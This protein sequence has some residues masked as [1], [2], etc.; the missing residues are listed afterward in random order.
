MALSGDAEGTVP[1]FIAVGDSDGY[2]TTTASSITTG[3]NIR[4][5]KTAP[6]ITVNGANPDTVFLNSQSYTDP[7]ASATDSYDGAVSVNTSGSVNTNVVGSYTLTYSAS[8]AAGNAASSTRTVNVVASQGG[9]GIVGSDFSA[10]PAPV[11]LA[12]NGGAPALTDTGGSS[13]SIA[14]IATS[15]AAS[16]T[17]ASLT[18]QLQ[19]LYQKIKAM[20]AATTSSAT[21]SRDLQYGD[22]GADVL[23][24]QQFLNTNGYVVATSGPGSPGEETGYFGSATRKSLIAFQKALGIMPTA[25][26]FGAKTRAIILE[27]K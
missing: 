20:Q 25:G 9:G 4:F 7:G 15:T 17:V 23:A 18:A 13:T 12:D 22:H 5:D 2:G 10:G 24:L 19:A 27:W 14:P 8:D 1:F 6:V 16:S 21:F 11:A 3:A 26:Y